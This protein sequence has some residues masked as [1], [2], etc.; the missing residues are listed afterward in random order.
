[1]WW[2]H[3]AYDRLVV[4]TI[5]SR[6]GD[7]FDITI[8]DLLMIGTAAGFQGLLNRLCVYF[9][10]ARNAL[11]ILGTK[12]QI[13]MAKDRWLRNVQSSFLKYRVKSED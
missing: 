8:I 9:T 10:R 7:E 11:Y 5:D 12:A 3:E 1:M 2:L 4:D 13:D 6:Q